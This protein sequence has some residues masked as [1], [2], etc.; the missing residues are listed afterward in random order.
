MFDIGKA[1]RNGVP[2]FVLR[3]MEEANKKMAASRKCS[4]HEFDMDEIKVAV[5]QSTVFDWQKA[6]VKCHRC[7][8]EFFALYAGGYI[9]ALNAK[10][11]KE[12]S[13][14]GTTDL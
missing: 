1:R 9:D 4:I 14:N 11:E 2:P 13:E 7:G 12:E 3:E 10:R 8:V 5:R 6:K